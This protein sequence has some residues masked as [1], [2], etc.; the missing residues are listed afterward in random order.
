VSVSGTSRKAAIAVLALPEAAAAALLAQLGAADLQRLQRAVDEVGEVAE[1]EVAAV[2]AEL[3]A[4]V[5]RPP[6]L[7]RSAE[8]GYLRRLA[9]RAFGDER[10]AELL[11]P[12]AAVPP[13]ARDRL[14]AA[15][16]AEL[17]QLLGEEHPQI[18]AMVLT[19]LPSERAARVLAAMSAELAAEVVARL[20]EIQ[21]VP[22][23]RVAQAAQAL[24]QAL[25]R[26]GGLDEA[27]AAE[28][29]DGLG[30]A[31]TVLR[32]LEAARS[33]PLLDEL[34]AR[35]RRAATQLRAAMLRP[36]EL[37]E[38]PAALAAAGAASG[39]APSAALSAAST[40]AQRE[41]S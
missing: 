14:S 39:P 31:A 7:A 38:A 13:R 17:A 16:I 1:H 9:Q 2:L 30:F 8:P 26:A 15:P 24:V 34:S 4:Q 28:R 29:F 3:A 20:A 11:A 22:E 5:R 6:A 12:P 40:A 41:L 36:S 10:A 35:D 33:A 23:Q 18:A 19:Q 25:E 37:A 21:E 27:A 32:E